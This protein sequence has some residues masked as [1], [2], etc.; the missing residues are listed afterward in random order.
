MT[1]KEGEKCIWKVARRQVL[2]K[3]V[4]LPHPKGSQVSGYCCRAQGRI[5]SGQ[6]FQQRLC[7]VALTAVPPSRPFSLLLLHE[8]SKKPKLGMKE[9]FGVLLKSK[10]LGFLA[11]L[12][13]GYGLCI[14]MTEGARESRRLPMPSVAYAANVR[15]VCSG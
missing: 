1:G 9:S 13:L 12:V 8:K 6:E 4:V 5:G 2:P 3:F 10:Y 11:T 14:N 7:V 15:N